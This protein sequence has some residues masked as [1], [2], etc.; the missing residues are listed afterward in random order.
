[1]VPVD[2]KLTW[3]MPRALDPLITVIAAWRV[4]RYLY[5]C[6][7]LQGPSAAQPNSSMNLQVHPCHHTAANHLRDRI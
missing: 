3:T 5:P 1:M 6:E 2:E 7:R 4:Y